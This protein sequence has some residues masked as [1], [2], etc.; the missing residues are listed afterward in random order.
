MAAVSIEEFL[1]GE[2][3]DDERAR[4]TALQVLEAGGL[5][6]PRKQGIDASKIERARRTLEQH[7]IR[8]CGR[9]CRSLVAPGRAPLLA[10]VSSQCQVCE[11]SNNRR[12]AL[13]LARAM[14]ARA[15]SKLLVIGGTGNLHRE[16][17]SLLSP[18]GVEVRGI[19]GAS[20]TPTQKEA[21]ADQR[22]ADLVVVWASTPL[23][24]K[25]SVLYTREPVGR[26]PLTVA[27]RGIE[28]LCTAM[29][30]SLERHGL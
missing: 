8:V 3:F 25:V 11:G 19:D 13:L 6:N 18:C 21:W 16:L 28:A 2:G 9:E 7:V 15:A 4:A 24:H 22:W 17:D 27:R 12:S 5:T 23:P 29:R 30:V 26:T 14:H 10:A 1:R 20:Q